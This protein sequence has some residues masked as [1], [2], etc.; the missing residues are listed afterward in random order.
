MN[1]EPTQ[2]FLNVKI[3]DLTPVVL[4]VF[5]QS[6]FDM[7]VLIADIV[8][9]VLP[10]A[11]VEY[12]FTLSTVVDLVE[13]E[14]AFDVFR[15]DLQDYLHGHF[16]KVYHDALIRLPDPVTEEQREMAVHDTEKS[17]AICLTVIEIC[18][19]CL[20]NLASDPMHPYYTVKSD[21]KPGHVLLCLEENDG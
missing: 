5:S 3:P 20:V 4:E 13:S 14:Q 12:G 18:W 21:L 17:T 8:N 9:E 15:T 7:G 2:I 6:G 10:A 1:N 16:D 19:S 11:F